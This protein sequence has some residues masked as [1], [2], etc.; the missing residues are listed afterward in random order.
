MRQ[1]TAQDGAVKIRIMGD[2]KLTRIGQAVEELHR[3]RRSGGGIVHQGGRIVER[4]GAKKNAGIFRIL[5]H[6]RVHWNGG[7]SL[8]IEP[9]HYFYPQKKGGELPPKSTT[10]E[11]N[12]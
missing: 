1:V 7:K 9:N 2:D 3:P 8:K 11:E 4:V 12:D 5:I 6:P 10:K